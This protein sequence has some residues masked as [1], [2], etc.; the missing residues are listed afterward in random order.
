MTAMIETTAEEK[1]T[2]PRLLVR[3]AARLGDKPL[4][5]FR[6]EG[7][8]TYAELAAAADAAS[9]RLRDHGLA[10]GEMAAL[11]L[12]NSL[13]YVRAWFGCLFAGIVD[14]PV[15]PEFRKATLLFALRSM[16][17]KAIFTNGEGIERLADPEVR[18]QVSALKV[19]VLAGDYDRGA[20]DAA[21]AGIAHCPPVVELRELMAPQPPAGLWHELRADAN[22]S[23]RL[24]SGTTG[25]A[26]GVMLTH[27]HIIARTAKHNEIMEMGEGDILYSPFPFHHTLA[28][29]NGLI[30]TLQAGA[31]MWSAPRFSA[32]RYFQDAGEFG[33]TRGHLIGAVS[34]LVALQP[35]GPWDRAHMIKYL[36]ASPPN[37]AFE[38]RFGARFIQMFGTSEIGCIA[39]K[40]GGPDGHRGNGP[41]VPEVEVRIHDDFDRPLPAGEVGEIVVRPRSPNRMLLGYFNNAPATMRAFRNLWYHTGDAG[42]LGEDGELYF[43]GRIGDTIRRRG[44]N[45]SS[46]MIEGE[47]RK[48]NAVEDCAVIAVPSETGEQ[49][50][51][52]CVLFKPG[53]GGGNAHADLLDLLAERLPRDY[54]PRFVEPVADLPRTGTGKVRKVEMRDRTTFG[55]TWDR[56][57]GT[58]VHDE[59][60]A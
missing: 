52:A 55:R 25:P 37:A 23:I 41:P 32:S 29:I 35:P 5:R 33:A 38:E 49:E 11:Y 34:Q 18:D 26:K 57:E 36:W 48:S 10:A 13:D 59:A 17:A 20:V 14:V 6:D 28:S 1:F 3:Q 19:I 43:A 46:E 2:I 22:C 40:R 42:Y 50:I 4:L 60:P 9:A 31:T 21:L 39:F 30:S 47:I 45:I 58:W 53:Q 15:N 51:H 8:L 44:V 7:D 24:T 16:E 56:Q 12:G 27:A 54:V